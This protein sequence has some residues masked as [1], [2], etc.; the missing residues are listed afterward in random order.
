MGK[1]DDELTERLLIEIEKNPCLYDKQ[2]SMYKDNEKKDDVWKNICTR[3][4]ITG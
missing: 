4:G 3:V 2:C 1:N